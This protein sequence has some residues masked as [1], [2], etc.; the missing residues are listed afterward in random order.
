MVARGKTVD[1]APTGTFKL[2][3]G[4]TL[5]VKQGKLTGGT[6]ASGARMVDWAVFALMPADRELAAE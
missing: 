5:T 4:K 3:N 6:A 2:P 1:A